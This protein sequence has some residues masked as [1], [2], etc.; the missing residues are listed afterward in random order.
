MQ[1]LTSSPK[2]WWALVA[3]VLCTLT[4][5]FDTT[6]LNVSLPTL[7]T[8]QEAGTSAR[9]WAVDA[10]VVVFAGLFLPLGALGDRYGRKRLML[11]GL[12]LFAAASLFAMYVSG[13]TGVIAARA[14]MGV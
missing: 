4:L 10:Y 13:A 1:T 11:V 12:A 8:K 2:R 14:V 5:G 6:I 3:I 7:A 9:Q